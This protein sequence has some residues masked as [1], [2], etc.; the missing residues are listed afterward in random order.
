MED[1]DEL[2]LL[3]VLSFCGLASLAAW[4]PVRRSGVPPSSEYTHVWL[5]L[6]R[7]C[8][9]VDEVN[10]LPRIKRAFASLS[11][12]QPSS[13]GWKA[14]LLS[15]LETSSLMAQR[16]HGDLVER[17]LLDA[18]G[19]CIA[20]VQRLGLTHFDVTGCFESSDWDVFLSALDDPGLAAPKAVYSDTLQ[21]FE[22]AIRF[23]LITEESGHPAFHGFA[24]MPDLNH[25]LWRAE[26]T[27]QFLHLVFTLFCGGVQRQ[28]EAYMGPGEEDILDQHLGYFQPWHVAPFW[29]HMPTHFE[30]LRQSVNLE[31]RS[32]SIEKPC[33]RWHCVQAIDAE[34]NEHLQSTDF[35][36]V[37]YNAENPFAT[38]PFEK[39]VFQGA[40][41]LIRQ[42]G[43]CGFAYKACA[44]R[45]AG[46]VGC[47]IWSSESLDL[48]QGP[49]VRT[50]QGRT[51]PDPEIPCVLV[52]EDAGRRIFAALQGGPLYVKIHIERNE[53]FQAFRRNVALGH[54]V[55]MAFLAES[56]IAKPGMGV[57][58]FQ[59]YF[60]RN[61]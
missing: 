29:V 54:R 9:E 27:R 22:T 42:G 35:H 51:S 11:V 53:S 24:F 60:F 41:A 18:D 50:F 26:G 28:C 57:V 25:L 13:G 45:A 59:E 48:L 56:I 23:G 36:R 1:L 21:V 46:A 39:Q 61:M 15:E 30:G 6:L 55:R 47:I 3:K 20:R 40:I 58:D 33:S 8:A 10:D 7:R 5:G 17:P 43:G 52:S 49:M 34:W 44:A 32:G 12:S 4:E 2:L 31:L 14:M 19:R 37:I 38:L 16:L